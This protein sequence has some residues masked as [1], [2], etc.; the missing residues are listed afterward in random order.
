MFE[1]TMW[2]YLSSLAGERGEDLGWRR[3]RTTSAAKRAMQHYTAAG[4]R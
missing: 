3:I 2:L 4:A 1:N